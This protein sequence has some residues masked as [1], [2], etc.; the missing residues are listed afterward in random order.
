M[1]FQLS[2]GVGPPPSQETDFCVECYG[3]IISGRTEKGFS[4]GGFLTL[5]EQGST[6]ERG[7][8]CTSETT[9]CSG[10]GAGVVHRHPRPPRDHGL[11]L[12]LGHPSAGDPAASPDLSCGPRWPPWRW[13]P[14]TSTT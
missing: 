1:V 8:K 5:V 4:G 9:F 7:E 10:W 2:L 14:P 11:A 6:C 13:T 3:K 12:H